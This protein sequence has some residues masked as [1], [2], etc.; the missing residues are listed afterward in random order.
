MLEKKELSNQLNALNLKFSLLP[1][2]HLNTLHDRLDEALHLHP[3]NPTFFE[4]YKKI[5]SFHLNNIT[6]TSILTIALYQPIGKIYFELGDRTLTTLLPPMYLYNVDPNNVNS[7]R[8]I[9]QLNRT[10]K[11]LL[12]KY[13]HTIDPINLPTKIC[14]S[15]SGLG[16]YGR[17][18]LCYID[19]S[20]FYW[21]TTYITDI[22]VTLDEINLSDF[23]LMPECE[24]CQ[25]CLNNCPT[26]ALNK[27][28]S[29]LEVYKC[30]TFHNESID[31]FPKWLLPKWHNSLIGC[32]RCQ[33]VCPI[34]RS[35]ITN[36]IEL[37]TFNQKETELILD[38]TPIRLLPDNL[39]FK[40]KTINFFEDYKLL[41]RNL[42]ILI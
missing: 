41:E 19:G 2:Q 4:K 5:F 31:D 32:M 3:D 14:A 25:N 18:N 28:S 17:N 30:L 12:A 26:Q 42:K 10:L 24:N 16:T 11:S 13:G 21:M 40:I 35:S 27:E 33:M 22:P 20:S 37:V 1:A 34:N 6:T 36:T 15:S 29:T 7:N 23:Q 9:K 39:K 38:K 8:H